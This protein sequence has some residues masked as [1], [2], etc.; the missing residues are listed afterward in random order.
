MQIVR[1]LFQRKLVDFSLF[2]H[3]RFIC[4]FNKTWKLELKVDKDSAR[5]NKNSTNEPIRLIVSVELKFHPTEDFPI[6]SEL[7]VAQTHIHT[8]REREI[9]GAIWKIVCRERKIAKSFRTNE[10]YVNTIDSMQ[11]CA[12]K[13]PNWRN[14]HV[15]WLAARE[16]RIG[17]C[18]KCIE[19][20]RAH[21]KQ[22]HMIPVSMPWK[23]DRERTGELLTCDSEMKVR[24][25]SNGLFLFLFG[26][27]LDS[28][29]NEGVYKAETICFWSISSRYCHQL[30]FYQ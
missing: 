6:T 16:Y 26:K 7:C 10:R 30:T 27:V 15:F 9:G 20:N 21:R 17:R 5:L 11:W 19:E 1:I 29:S 14:I 18:I 3:S 13:P 2:V 4:F 23:C 28:C 8:L 24:T 22:I 12:L 25:A